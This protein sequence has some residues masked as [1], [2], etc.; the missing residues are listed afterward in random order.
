VK[1]IIE[2]HGGAIDLRSQEGQGT[3]VVVRLPVVPA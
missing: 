2:R 1:G 3:T